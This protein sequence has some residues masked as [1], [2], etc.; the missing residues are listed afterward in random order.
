VHYTTRR[1]SDNNEGQSDPAADESPGHSDLFSPPSIW[2]I[3]IFKGRSPA[4]R[5]NPGIHLERGFSRVEGMRA[6][7]TVWARMAG[8]GIDLDEID[9]WK[10]RLCADGFVEGRDFR[11]ILVLHLV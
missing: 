6:Q 8:S 2:T 4:V 9:R 11:R 1:H 3:R 5:I 7:A 10:Q